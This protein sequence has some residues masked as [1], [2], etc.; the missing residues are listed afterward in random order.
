MH[1]KCKLKK[2]TFLVEFT[3]RT[4]NLGPS[5]YGLV[6]DGN[7]KICC[8]GFILAPFQSTTANKTDSEQYARLLRISDGFL[9]KVPKIAKK[10]T[11]VINNKYNNTVLK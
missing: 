4:Q 9:L 11:L 2:K 7:T 6:T 10:G 3:A 8:L 1:L 5:I